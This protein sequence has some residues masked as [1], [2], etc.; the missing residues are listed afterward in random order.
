MF[1]RFRGIQRFLFSEALI[2]SVPGNKPPSLADNP[3]GRYAG[4]L[5]AAA[6]SIESLHIVNDDLKYVNDLIK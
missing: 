3:P 6:S 1:M 2:K 4:A 5:F